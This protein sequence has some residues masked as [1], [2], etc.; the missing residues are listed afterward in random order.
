MRPESEVELA[1]LEPAT[2]WVRLAPGGS[3]TVFFGLVEPS[4]IG[5]V[6]PNSL[7]LVARLVARTA[8]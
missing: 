2:S 4:G 1:R 6:Q 3:R 7:S 8:L 5:S